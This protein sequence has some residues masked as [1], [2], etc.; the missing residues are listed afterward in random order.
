MVNIK[1]LKVLYFSS[2]THIQGGAVLSMFRMAKWLKTQGDLPLVVLPRKGGIN[3]LYEEEGIEIVVIPFLEVRRN[4]SLSYIIRYLFSTIRLIII[5][6]RLINIKGIELVHVN[7]LFY[8]PALIAGKIASAYT[9]CHIRVILRRPIWAKWILAH[10][11][12]IF[13]DRI[14]CVSNAVKSETV[15]TIAHAH[16]L[17]DPG[18][19]GNRFRPISMEAAILARQEFGI[20]KDSFVVGQVSKFVPNKG[21]QMLIEAARLCFDQSPRLDMKF[22]QVGGGVSGYEKYSAAIRSSIE[23]YGLSSA[24]I[25]TGV[26]EDIPNLMGM[27]DVLV[28]LP[29]HE[30]PFPGV[31]LEAMAMAKPLVATFSGGIPEQFEHGVSGYL[32][33]KADVHTLSDL[34]LMLEADPARRHQV[35]EAARMHLVSKFN[36]EGFF[37]ALRRIYSEFAN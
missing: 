21:H 9:I 3:R 12:T 22:L 10:L 19:D 2:A 16:T 30:D 20:G 37:T 1:P 23:Q 28:H 4:P 31:V 17:H 5:L 27:C 13:S 24:F 18:P 11:V 29:M 8:F 33:A 36:E 25:L 26:R 7:E 32:I 35:G 34:I 15:P 6:V 14:L